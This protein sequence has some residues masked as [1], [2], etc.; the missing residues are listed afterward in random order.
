MHSL[1][2]HSGGLYSTAEGLYSTGGATAEV[3]LL[4]TAEGH[5]STGGATASNGG[6]KERAIL[7]MKEKVFSVATTMALIACEGQPRLPAILSQSA[8]LVLF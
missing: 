5:Y 3:H 8:L 4:T 2:V 7:Q 1:Y 6:K